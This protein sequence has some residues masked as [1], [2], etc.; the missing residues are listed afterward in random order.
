MGAIPSH[1]TGCGHP[2]RKKSPERIVIAANRREGH[3]CQD[4]ENYQQCSDKMKIEWRP[5]GLS[6]GR[7]LVC[8][9]PAVTVKQLGWGTSSQRL[10]YKGGTVKERRI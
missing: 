5:L 7:S 6:S 10:K 9:I 4:G 3:F 2:G 8:F 1:G